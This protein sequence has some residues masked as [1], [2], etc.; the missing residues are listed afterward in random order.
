MTWWWRKGRQ[1]PEIAPDE[2]FLDAANSPSFDRARFEGRLERPL[3]NAPF[4]L[5]SSALGLVFL[6]LIG[7]VWNLQIRLGS[8]YAAQSERNSLSSKVLFANRGIITDVQGTVLVTNEATPEG[9]VTR[10]YETP[11][12]GSIVGY[13]S[14]PKKD[15]SGNYYDTD[16]TG[17]A[18]VESY[19]NTAL[20]G[21]N[22]TVLVERNALGD[23]ESQGVVT[24]PVNGTDLSLSV[25]SRAQKAFYESVRGLADT[26]PFLGGAGVLMD[27][28]TGAIRALVSYPEYDP[29]VLSSGGPAD[30]I[31]GYG[32]SSRKPYL[33]RAVAGLYTPGSIVKPLEATGALTDGVITPDLTINDTGSISVPNPYDLAHPSVF[34]DWKALG[35][36]DLRRAIAFSSDVYF[37]MVGGGYGGQKGLGIERLAYWYRAFGLTSPTGIE[38]PNESSGFVPTPSWKQETYDEIWRIGDTYHTAIGQYAMQVTPIEIA[39]AFAAI[40]NGGKFVQPS[41]KKDAPLI[42]ESL[43]VSGDALQVVR[44][45]MR[46]GVEEGTSIG[47]SSLD[48]FVHIAGK[49]GTAQTGVH[50]EYYNSWAVGFFP[51]EHPKYVYV[52]VMEKGPAGNPTGGVYVIN[53]FLTKLHQV[54]PE[55]FQ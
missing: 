32:A 33:D 11:G 9:G 2:I 28:D 21:K 55:Y 22:G 53:Q 19:F 35:V 48:S 17:L 37:Y 12:M 16:I 26:V 13:V 3:G 23:V 40:A 18:G 14:Y 27:V 52:V 15:S 29:N 31:A 51:Y 30:V 41:L 36:E 7:Q 25:D 24:P 8:V 38:L 45:G 6:I 50:N 34:L 44:E 4:A 47:L 42:G 39:R 10:V 54:A 49:T 5:F 20:A 46:R 1:D 43:A